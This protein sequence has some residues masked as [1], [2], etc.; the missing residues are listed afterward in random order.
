MSPTNPVMAE[1]LPEVTVEVR[2]QI[3]P[4]AVE[5][6]RAKVLAVI[7]RN[8]P[9]PVLFAKVK[10][11]VAADPAVARPA[12]ARASL[13]VNGRAVRAHVA[14]QTLRAATDLLHDRL[15][16]QLTRLHLH[17]HRGGLPANAQNEWRHEA[18]P[19][20]RPVHYRRPASQRQLVRHKSFALAAETP[21]EAAFDMETM[22][23][24]FYL[25]ADLETTQDSVIYR[26][27]GA[28]R[29]AQLDPKPGRDTAAPAVPLTISPHPAPGLTPAEAAQRL[30]LT[31]LPFIFF[32]DQ[33][34]GR[35]NVLYHRYDG[36]YGLITPA[37]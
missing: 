31:G 27:G 2:G 3:P 22:D 10:L 16:A 29:M 20:Q 34:T 9:E 24:S 5:Y 12:L 28:Y 18:Q 13:D 37:S 36:H 19:A 23:Y 17:P 1:H 35:G 15:R 21:D 6:A 33:D 11:A 4:R 32:A 14:A 8:A 26:S 7:G 25:F 30:E